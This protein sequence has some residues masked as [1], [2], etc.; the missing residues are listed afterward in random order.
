VLTE[1]KVDEIDARLENFLE[2]PL[3]ALY[4]RLGFRV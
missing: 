3:D 4:R 2:N 1:E